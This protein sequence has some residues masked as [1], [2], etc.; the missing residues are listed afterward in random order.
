VVV[1]HTD[2][3]S[4]PRRRRPAQRGLPFG[5]PLDRVPHGT[6]P[7]APGMRPLGPVEPVPVA[8]IGAGTPVAPPRVADYGA[9][10]ASW[11]LAD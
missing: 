5:A 10:A 7:P 1:I 2:L 8:L 4:R 6:A 9:M 11:P 3:R